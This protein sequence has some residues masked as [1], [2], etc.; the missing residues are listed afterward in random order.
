MKYFSETK[1]GGTAEES[2]RTQLWLQTETL[3]KI[4]FPVGTL[5]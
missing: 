2:F 4:S 1:P 5:D 3:F